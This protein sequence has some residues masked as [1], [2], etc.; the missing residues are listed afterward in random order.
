MSK[1][2]K[3]SELNKKINDL[4]KKNEL[5]FL[6]KFVDSLEKD[7]ANRKNYVYDKLFRFFSIDLTIFP[8]I[9]VIFTV[10][11]SYNISSLLLAT[12]CFFIAIFYKFYILT[13]KLKSFITPTIALDQL[14]EKEREKEFL[15]HRMDKIKAIDKHYFDNDKMINLINHSICF[16][17][18]SIT[19]S[20]T[21]ILQV[22]LIEINIDINFTLWV[23]FIINIITF[24]LAC[25]YKSLRKHN[26]KIKSFFIKF[27][28]WK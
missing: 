23:I 19:I 20:L 12:C 21:N 15:R 3:F 4:E 26:E 22:I 18:S 25:F 28:F 27:K 17:M 5:N 8:L 10:S 24:S 9:T 6:E 1:I 2:D 16:T 7:R 11:G 14:N 13:F